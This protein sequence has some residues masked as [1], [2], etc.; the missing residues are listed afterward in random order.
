MLNQLHVPTFIGDGLSSKMSLSKVKVMVAGSV[1]GRLDLLDARITKINSSKVGPFD[2]VLCTGRFHPRSPNSDE[3]VHNA[4]FGDYIKGSKRLPIPTYF[5]VNDG[6]DGSLLKDSPEGA[7]VAE[8]LFFLGSAGVQDLAGISVG[9]ICQSTDEKSKAALLSAA[10]KSGPQGLDILLSNEWP[11]GVLNFTPAATIPLSNEQE[12]AMTL[13]MQEIAKTVHPRYHFAASM[14]AFLQRPPFSSPPTSTAAVLF[15]RFV[16]IA[17][18][19]ESTAK[20]HKWLHALS[21]TPA[22]QLLAA[23]GEKNL[24]Q[25]QV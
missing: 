17:N 9:Y 5:L 16:A 3:A 6:S 23:G 18:V 2:I 22:R 14:G 10:T 12:V 21:L 25:L 7:K 19:S 20:E 8:N 13:E 15:T 24:A 1:N 11:E 4:Q